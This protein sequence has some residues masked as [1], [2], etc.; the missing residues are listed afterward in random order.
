MTRSADPDRPV[1][2][3]RLA[4]G[5]G[6]TAGRR[7]RRTLALLVFVPTAGLAPS[8]PILAGQV[9]QAYAEAER[10]SCG[11]RV[12]YA[13]ARRLGYNVTY[14]TVR[15]RM[16]LMDDGVAIQDVKKAL[17]DLDIACSVRRLDP[18]QLYS[19]PTPLIVHIKPI[20]REITDGHYLIASE[21]GTDGVQTYDPYTGRVALW[22]WKSFSDLWTGYVVIPER[23]S[24]ARGT[25]LALAAALA[26]HVL[27]FVG[28]VSSIRVARRARRPLPA[29][30]GQGRDVARAVLIIVTSG[31]LASPA[32]AADEALRAHANDGIN[33]AALLGGIYG[34][35]IVPGR[36]AGSRASTLVEVQSLLADHGVA[37]RV[38]RL[39]YDDLLHHTGPCIVPLRFGKDGAGEFSVMV[40]ANPEYVTVVRAGLLLV[41]T[42][43]VDEFRRRWSGLALLTV[44][45]DSRAAYLAA[46]AGVLVI[47]A[48]AYAVGRR[49]RRA[50]T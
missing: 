24:S 30:A 41:N 46:T 21:I 32:V 50:A 5:T 16:Q 17:N 2:A 23:S 47:P 20:G 35:K 33:A 11:P 19:C 39:T 4:P 14:E 15:R 9:T 13:L 1:A 3:R 42:I 28:L 12:V 27:A 7:F 49:G 31:L 38:R 43:S 29:L 34:A 6:E 18:T 10:V 36:A 45:D 8:K 25:G 48:L 40:N 22:K 26:V 44:R 37:S